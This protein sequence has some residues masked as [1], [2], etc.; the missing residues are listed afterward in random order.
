[1][2]TFVD[3]YAVLGIEPTATPGEIKKAY[4]QLA[5]K[6]HPDKAAPGTKADP[7]K[8]ISALAA[9]E[10][11]ANESQR[12]A[13]DIQYQNVKAA[14]ANST[15]LYH[16]SGTTRFNQ[17]GTNGNPSGGFW[18]HPARDGEGANTPGA[19]PSDDDSSEPDDSSD[20]DTGFYEDGYTE[21][22]YNPNHGRTYENDDFDDSDFYTEPFDASYNRHQ[23][24]HDFAEEAASP[25]R[26]HGNE[27][28]PRG[29]HDRDDEST[30]PKISDPVEEAC[31]IFAEIEESKYLGEKVKGRYHQNALDELRLQKARYKDIDTNLDHITGQ[32]RRRASSMPANSFDLEVLDRA[33]K[34][35]MDAAHRMIRTAQLEINNAIFVMRFQQKPRSWKATDKTTRSVTDTIERNAGDLSQMKKE[36]SGLEGIVVELEGWTDSDVRQ[37]CG[38][39]DSFMD[40]LRDWCEEIASRP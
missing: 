13:Y 22:H 25:A 18:S 21:I 38:C 28:G 10:V 27:S 12:K 17:Q 32:L 24:P 9:Y 36:L 39:L 20:E 7:S 2:A 26:G 16:N 5:L 6:H 14:A 33:L 34:K 35:R 3:Y 15:T 40:G 19:Y 30:A 8:F 4:H 23:F 31:D 1:M 29:E 11:L 37:L